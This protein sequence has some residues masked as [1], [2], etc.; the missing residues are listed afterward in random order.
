[1]PRFLFGRYF[2]RLPIFRICSFICFFFFSNQ[3]AINPWEATQFLLKTAIEQGGFYLFFVRMCL[4][5]MM[6][7]N[8]SVWLF[9]T[10]EETFLDY[11]EYDNSSIVC[12][13]SY[14]AC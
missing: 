11:C 3:I 6:A 1:M 14:A 5:L 13:T 10:M 7:T 2:Q 12:N 9:V 8:T 4:G